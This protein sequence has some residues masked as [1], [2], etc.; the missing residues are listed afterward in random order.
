MDRPSPENPKPRP[1]PPGPRKERRLNLRA[2]LVLG[3]LLALGVPAAI[4]VAY[5]RNSHGGGVLKAQARASLE[6]RPPQ[7]ELALKYL[8]SYLKQAPRDVEALE[9]RAKILSDTA[10]NGPMVKAALDANEY[11]VRQDPDGPGRGETRR[12]L[13]ELYLRMEQFA[14]KDQVQYRT[15]ATL[16]ERLIKEDREAGKPDAR[17]HRLLGRALLGRADLGEVKSLPLAVEQFE[18]AFRLDPS[19]TPGA[20]LLANLYQ[21]RLKDGAKADAVLD[22]LLEANPKPEARMARI[23]HYLRAERRDEAR[24]ELARAVEAFPANLDIRLIAAE[25]ALNREDLAAARAHLAAIPEA[26]AADDVRF[27]LLRGL[28]ELRENQA[29]DAISDWRQGLRLTQGSNSDLTYHLAEVMLNLGRLE[30]ARPLMEQFERLTGGADKARSPSYR[31]LEAL[32]D[33]KMGQPRRA[34]ATLEAIQEKA[35]GQFR[36]RVFVMLGRCREATG[37]PQ[38]AIEAYR[39]AAKAA[40]NL[41]APR[42]RL[43]ELLQARGPGAEG[44][45]AAA[46]ELQAG[47]EAAP[48]DTTLLLGL[49]RI[50]LA[51]R[52]WAAMKAALDRAAKVAPGDPRLITLQADY[53]AGIGKLDQAAALLGKAAETIDRRNAGYWVA[54]ANAQARQGHL[55]EAM[56]VLERGAKDDAA[57]DR[58]AI[59]VA[60]AQLQ[61]SAGK[62]KKAR[63]DLDRNLKEL[64][65]SDRPIVLRAKADLLFQ[66]DMK[67]EGLA[68]LTELARALPDDPTAALLLLDHAVADGDE[69]AAAAAVEALSKVKRAEGAYELIGR[70]YELIRMMPPGLSPEKRAARL[71][72]AA[73]VVAKLREKAPQ[74]AEPYSLE[75]LLLE[76]RAEAAG[77]AGEA[78]GRDK[79]LDGAIDAYQKAMAARSGPAVERRL[80]ALL[81]A[82]NRADELEALRKKSASPRGFD[83]NLALISTQSGL[84]GMAMQAMERLLKGDPESQDVVRIEA[85]ILSKFGRPKDAEKALREL[86][87]AR[88]GEPGPWFLL[89]QFQARRGESDAARAT[90]EQIR[91][92]VS[93]ERP[94]FLHAQAYRMAGDAKR[95]GELYR[96]SLKKWPEDAGIARATAGYFSAVGK[97]EEAESVLQAFLDADPTATWAARQLAVLLAGRPKDAASWGRAWKLVGPGASGAGD[98][99]EDRLARAIVLLKSPDP[100]VSA[101]AVAELK[102]LKEDLPPKHPIGA[103]ARALLVRF[104]LDNNQSS[105]AR[106]AA[107]EASSSTEELSATNGALFA[108]ALLRYGK[109]EEARK[110]VAR[111]VEMEP[112]ALRTEIMRARLLQAEDKPEEAVALLEK[113]YAERE[114]AD[115]VANSAAQII[116]ALLDLKHP[117]AAGRI[118]RVEA[119]RRPE[120]GWLLAKVLDSQGHADEALKACLDAVRKG[121]SRLAVRQA[122]AMAVTRGASPETLQGADDVISAAL[123]AQPDDLQLILD[124][125]QVRH[126]QGRFEDEL[127]AYREA[128]ARKPVDLSFLNNMAWTLS[129][130]LDRPADALKPIEDA[131]E[132]VG[133][134]PQFLDTRGVILARLNRLDEAIRDLE[135]A[136]KASPA[137]TSSL[138]LARVLKKAGK[139]AE[140]RRAL[141]RGKVEGK[142]PERLDDKERKEWEALDASLPRA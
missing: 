66:M 7:V 63:E 17:D 23:F 15:A 9:M 1:S 140:A 99:P 59:R 5:L 43:A 12:R 125:A 24:R 115:D 95:A 44:L 106:E 45:A 78:E 132:R 138:H 60:R 100:T 127:K 124:R 6:A 37:E 110:Q 130:S 69:A 16:A 14:P 116:G 41:A 105:E 30:D 122:V 102:S 10:R 120:T 133:R 103:E 137:G 113:S 108:D 58:A 21:G 83:Q 87:E 117:E 71:D 55:D 92:R 79:L 49:A 97:P 118:A 90:A 107:L 27:R 47:L 81:A 134:I 35:T 89:L 32:R 2:A 50:G 114:K 72:E 142:P 96:E 93:G 64:P 141:E 85:E 77:L 29:D 112:R 101:G 40:P 111:L 84:E 18:E 39:E 48:D 94:E 22:A 46:A 74:M 128:A 139:P 51:R 70:A 73:A 56:N 126:L 119:E 61:L 36:G 104:F 38:K 82:R 98:S 91:K 123:K 31:Y 131:L 42:I 129:E 4:A 68:M 13:A 28:A 62:G 3:A 53:L 20:A 80:I 19:D 121:K 67:A 25:D 54:W 75:G 11:L 8:D 88:G 86:A 135:V 34:I 76:R 26:E 65:P 57:G 52:D 109:V 136:A 33:I